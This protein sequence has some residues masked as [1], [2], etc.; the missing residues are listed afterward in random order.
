MGLIPVDAIRFPP[1]MSQISEHVSL[2]SQ[3]RQQMAPVKPATSGPLR[4]ALKAHVRY[5]MKPATSG[6]ICNKH[7]STSGRLTC[8]TV[9]WLAPKTRK[10]NVQRPQ[11]MTLCLSVLA[12]ALRYHPFC[13]GS[14]PATFFPSFYS[15]RR[16]SRNKQKERP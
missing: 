16:D 14:I 13:P 15:E 7:S 5:H 12:S 9:M 4:A 3:A 6:T 1:L 11:I 8:S 10:L 2:N